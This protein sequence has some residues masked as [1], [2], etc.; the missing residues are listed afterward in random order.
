MAAAGDVDGDRMPDLLV[1][2]PY[3]D[4]YTG[5]SGAAYL[6]THASFP[7]G[8]GEFN[9]SN[10]DFIFA[11]GGTSK[12]GK[13]IAIV[14]MDSVTSTAMDSMTSSLGPEKAISVAM[15]TRCGLHC[16]L[17]ELWNRGWDM[18]L[19]RYDA[20]MTGNG[21]EDFTGMDAFR[22]AGDVDGDGKEHHHWCS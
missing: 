14:S 13:A 17:I 20:H 4:D 9:L 6:V 12:S 8:G 3:N 15:S 1:G 7:E 11:C 10:A 2:S 22:S 21:V 19:R 5:S 18:N 16:L